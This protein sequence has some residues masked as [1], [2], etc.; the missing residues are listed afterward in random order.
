MTTPTDRQ[1]Q[2]IQLERNDDVPLVRDRMSFLRGKRALIIWPERGTTLTRKLDI[3][4]VQREARRRAVQIAFVT[5]DAEVIKNAHELGISTFETIQE[6]ERGRWKRGWGK[7]TAKRY[8]KPL[9]EPE[10]D[11]LKNVASRVTN[12]R[13]RSRIRH[14]LERIVV[15]AVLLAVLGGAAYVLI[16]SAD[17]TIYLETQQIEVTVSITANTSVLDVDVENAV[18]PA[19]LLPATAQTTVSMPTTGSENL[20][21]SRAIGVVTFTNNTNSAIDIPE[22]TIVRATNT[23]T[24]VDFVTASDS[25][26]PAGE[27]RTVDVSITADDDFSGPVGNVEAGVINTI[28]GP[29]ED[30]VTVR[31]VRATINGDSQSLRI[32]T[33]ADRDSLLSQA[34]AQLQNTAYSEMKRTLG[35]NQDIIIS[36]IR[37]APDGERDDWTVF[38]NNV[39]DVAD[40]L[41]LRMQAVVEAVAVDTLLARQIVFAALS[42][43]KPRGLVFDTDTLVYSDPGDYSVNEAGQIIFEMRGQAT[44]VGQFGQGQLQQQ[45][46]TLPIDEAMSIITAYPGVDAERDPLIEVVPGWYEGRMPIM[47]IRITVHAEVPQTEE[48]Q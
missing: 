20:G 4:M 37:I 22:G 25:T 26:L 2:Y 46:A 41:T 47:P 45:I 10:P 48:A 34:R 7:V 28:V 18:I 30:Q 23:G 5:H 32:V 14:Y 36:T 29:L 3:V 11:Q 17:V 31:N 44:A 21:E 27:G 33:T 15:L 38:S 42:S 9:D 19:T 35:P 24:P 12:R 13:Q 8:Q 16:P 6:A 43:A 1:I 40:T 39:G